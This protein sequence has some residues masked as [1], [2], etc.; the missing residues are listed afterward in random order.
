MSSLRKYS[1]LVNNVT[2]EMLLSGLVDD[3]DIPDEDDISNA[4]YTIGKNTNKRGESVWVLNNKVA[5]HK[6]G[7]LANP[8]DF[9]FEWL[10]DVTDGDGVLIARAN[11]SCSIQTPLSAE[12]FD[13][14]CHFL[15]GTLAY[16]CQTNEDFGTIVNRILGFDLEF[17]LEAGD[18]NQLLVPPAEKE[19]NRANFLL[20][21]FL[22]SQAVIFANYPGVSFVFFS[23][24]IYNL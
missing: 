22:A 6:T 3:I 10:G 12:S 23:Y 16:K 7:Q 5:I 4:V 18:G 19:K 14:M 17:P 20:Q 1:L 15:A 13:I 9:G 21:F 11:D 8:R 24:S 2:L